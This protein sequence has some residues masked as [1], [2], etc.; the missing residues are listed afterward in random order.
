MVKI[1]YATI[2]PHVDFDEPKI[3]DSPG[4]IVTQVEVPKEESTTNVVVSSATE[5]I[6][7]LTFEEIKK[8]GNKNEVE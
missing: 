8:K 7:N 1:D 5:E 6:L 2:I 3:L 4:I